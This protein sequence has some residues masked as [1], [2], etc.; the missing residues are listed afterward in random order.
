MTDKTKLDFENHLHDTEAR[1]FAIRTRFRCEKVVQKQLSSKNVTAYL[2]LQKHLR[3]WER[4][5]K[6][7]EL[8]LITCY[9][10]VKIVKA[11]YVKVL[12]TEHVVGFVKFS[13]NLI[14][15]PEEEIDIISRVVAENI[16]TEILPAF[17]TTGQ[18]I[19]IAW[20]RLSGIQGK[21]VSIEGK[22][23]VVVELDHIGYSLRI[24]VNPEWLKI[25]K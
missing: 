19:E 1:W 7:V 3:K 16:D 11:D 22:H 12:E 20:G 14:A 15:I 25:L 9:V 24:T 18:M 6:I 13:K 5:K 8:P 17:L 21:L 10:F 4:K 2:P 23:S